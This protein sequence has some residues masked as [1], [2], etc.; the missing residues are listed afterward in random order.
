MKSF[1]KISEAL[2]EEKKIL[3]ESKQIEECSEEEKEKLLSILKEG[4]L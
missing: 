2:K 1:S 4:L 3:C